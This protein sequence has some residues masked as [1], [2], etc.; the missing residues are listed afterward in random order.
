MPIDDLMRRLE[1]GVDGVVGRLYPPMH[2]AANVVDL[3]RM[4]A[5]RGAPMAPEAGAESV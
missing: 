4:R 5:P 3:P 2:A 1:P